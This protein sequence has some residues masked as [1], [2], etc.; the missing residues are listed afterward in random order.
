MFGIVAFVFWYVKYP[1]ALAYQ[2]QFQLF[3]SGTSYLNEMLAM[4]GGFARYVSEFLVQFNNVVML[5]AVIMAILFVLMQVLT[6]LLMRSNRQA[7]S[8]SNGDMGVLIWYSLSF[9]PALSLWYTLGDESV[10]MAFV[11]SLLFCLLAMLCWPCCQ[12]NGGRGAKTLRI[13]YAIV[14]V[15]VVYWLAGP[16]VWIFAAYAVLRLIIIA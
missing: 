12:D 4:P 3:M 7:V 2:E 9:L 15:P 5:G 8:S 14:V 1:H 11:V 10:L 13:V 16:L 6:W